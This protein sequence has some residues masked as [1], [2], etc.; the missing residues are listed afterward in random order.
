MLGF[1]FIMGMTVFV[2]CRAET[3]SSGF[4]EQGV[5]GFGVSKQSL[6]PAA[7]I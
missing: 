1:T 3:E 6:Q 2:F 5:I 7:E 4:F